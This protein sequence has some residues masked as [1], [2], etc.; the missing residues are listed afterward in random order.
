VTV[1]ATVALAADQF[2]VKSLPAV[3]VEQ[4][5]T[6]ATVAKAAATVRLILPQ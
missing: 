5:V 1:V 4:V 6:P 3:E 2:K